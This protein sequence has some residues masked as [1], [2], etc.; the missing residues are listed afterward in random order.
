MKKVNNVKTNLE[1]E[2]SERDLVWFLCLMAYQ[3][4]VGLFN[5]NAILLEKTLMYYL[6]HSWED[7]GWFIPFPRVFARKW[8]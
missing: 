7:K 6:T 4:T 8:M 2:E 5:A 3:P 1:M